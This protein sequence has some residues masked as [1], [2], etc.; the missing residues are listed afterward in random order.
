[1]NRHYLLAVLSIF[2]LA[3]TVFSVVRD[4]Q[5]AMPDKAPGADAHHLPARSQAPE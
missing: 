3:L 2:G 4:D 5:V 1:M